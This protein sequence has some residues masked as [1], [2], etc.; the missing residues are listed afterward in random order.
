MLA[1]NEC[2]VAVKQIP[3]TEI[4]SQTPLALA[5]LFWVQPTASI[6]LS[7]DHG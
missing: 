1:F 7:E 4:H 5:C 2:K 6:S 3:Y